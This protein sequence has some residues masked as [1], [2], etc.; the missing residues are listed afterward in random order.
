MLIGSRSKDS[1]HN[2]GPDRSRESSGSNPQPA[3][4]AEWKLSTRTRRAA[5]TDLAIDFVVSFVGSLIEVRPNHA[6]V[7]PIDLSMP[8]D[9]LLGL[10][11]GEIVAPQTPLRFSSA[12]QHAR[13][14]TA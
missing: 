14:D 13:M 1:D 10:S 2:A 5:R 3:A 4:L 12:R 7:L 6:D 8:R 11:I 9:G